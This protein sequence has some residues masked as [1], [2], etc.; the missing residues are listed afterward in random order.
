[1]DLKRGLAAQIVMDG[2]LRDLTNPTTQFKIQGALPIPDR[3]GKQNGAYSF[4]GKSSISVRGNPTLQ[5][6]GSLTV[7][8][9][10]RPRL[11]TAYAAWVSHVRSVGWGSKWRV[12]FGSSPTSQWGPTILA[13]RWFDYWKNGDELPPGKWAHIASVF[14]QTLGTLKV[15]RDGKLAKEFYGSSM[16]TQ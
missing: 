1:M 9:W 16:G 4:D 2:N 10:I 5:T 6:A 12:R 14:D 3:N 8:T 7:S 11:P 15:Y 13:E